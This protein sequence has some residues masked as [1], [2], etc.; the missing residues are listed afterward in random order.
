MSCG[1]AIC[2]MKCKAR[3]NSVCPICGQTVSYLIHATQPEAEDSY[4]RQASSMQ[5]D[6]VEKVSNLI[7]LSSREMSDEEGG[8]PK[9]MSSQDNLSRS[10]SPIENNRRGQPTDGLALPYA[11][12]RS[13]T[14]LG[15]PSISQGG[16]GLVGRNNFVHAKG[17]KFERTSQLSSLVGPGHPAKSRGPLAHKEVRQLSRG[18]ISERDEEQSNASKHEVQ[19]N[20]EA[21]QLLKNTSIDQISMARGAGVFGTPSAMHDEE[22]SQPDVRLAGTKPIN[23]RSQIDYSEEHSLDDQVNEQQVNMSRINW[24]ADISGNDIQSHTSGPSGHSRLQGVEISN[25]PTSE[26]EVDD[27][28]DEWS[29]GFE[30]KQ[31]LKI[32]SRKQFLQG[33]LRRDQTNR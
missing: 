28:Q 27:D 2:C 33:A 8:K 13:P 26:D 22:A 24:D 31:R 29:Q 9:A 30:E 10:Q 6:E 20:L 15:T 12:D 3:A 7:R 16:R 19:Q 14:L 21:N 32:A 5:Q 25:P 4:S 18:D 11:P 23:M 1:H 17:R